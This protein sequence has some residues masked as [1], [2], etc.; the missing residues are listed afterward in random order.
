MKQKAVIIAGSA[1]VGKTV[2]AQK[3]ANVIDLES[4]PFA[5]DYSKI[6]DYS[7]EEM[8][9]NPNRIPNP[10]FPN[11]YITAINNAI[12]KYDFVL[13]WANLQKSFPHLPKEA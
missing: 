6:G 4:S 3:Y 1:G 2:L 9:G 5:W 12:Q 7:P 11:N 10:N 8:K 13:V